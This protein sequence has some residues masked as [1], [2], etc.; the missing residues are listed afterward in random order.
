MI[1]MKGQATMMNILK[2][3]IWNTVRMRLTAVN[4][5]LSGPISV[6]TSPWLTSLMIKLMMLSLLAEAASRYANMMSAP[7]KIGAAHFP[8][9]I[10]INA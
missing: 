7:D 6:S 10:A 3:W 9:F 1:D 8:F 4:K 2:P 5:K